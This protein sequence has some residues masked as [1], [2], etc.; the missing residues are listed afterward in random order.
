MRGPN[1]VYV[2]MFDALGA[3]GTTTDWSEIYG[4]LQTGVIDGMEASPDMIYSMK[5]HEVAGY[6]SK[7][8][9]I[10]ACVYYMTRKDWLEELPEDLQEIVISSA[11]EAAAFQNAL[12]VEAQGKSLQKMIDE[13]LA[14]NEVNDLGEFQ[15]T[16]EA[17]KSSYVEEKGPEWVDLYN[18]IQA[19]E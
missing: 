3:S 1:P 6:L 11:R 4:A 12:D 10:A 5:F 13:G 14:V 8:Y 17:F 9:H 19:V 16:L 2:G 7:T 18:K 15:T